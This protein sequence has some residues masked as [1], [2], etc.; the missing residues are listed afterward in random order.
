L[1]GPITLEKL[2]DGDGLLAGV[3]VGGG[4][5]AKDTIDG[6]E[7]DAVDAVLAALIPLH[8]AQEV[9]HVDV[10]VLQ[11]LAARGARQSGGV[12][13]RK[14][15]DRSRKVGKGAGTE[16]WRR[17][18]RRGWESLGDAVQS[19][20]ARHVRGRKDSVGEVC[21]GF[22]G[23]GEP[24]GAFHPAHGASEGEGHEGSTVGGGN[25]DNA[26]GEDVGRA[27]M[28][29][30]EAVGD[31]FLGH[32]HGAMAGV[33]M[34]DLLEEAGKTAAKLH[35][36][37]GGQPNCLL[38]DMRVAVVNDGS[39]PALVLRDNADGG[40]T[41]G[42]EMADV[43]VGEDHP[44]A[45]S[46]HA[47]HLVIEIVRE[48]KGGF[49]RSSCHGGIFACEAP[50]GGRDLAWD[51]VV[52]HVFEEAGC[53]VGESADVVREVCWGSETVNRVVPAMSPEEGG[54]LIDVRT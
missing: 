26:K 5:R 30:V 8:Q 12:G 42:S 38:V 49:M 47:R 19:M 32:A 41:Q 43:G 15:G 35:G 17:W 52:A 37:R 27:G 10:D 23:G 29:A 34:D 16:E 11:G 3:G 39:G 22:S 13:L 33:G 50:L 4:Q 28:Q 36:L 45:A 14:G 31:V 6:L 9:V 46:N 51:P 25:E 48:F 1:P 24:G 53:R 40:E 54:S 21:P 18:G 44:L 20:R 2:F 7:E